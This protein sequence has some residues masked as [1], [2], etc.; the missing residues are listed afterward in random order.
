MHNTLTTKFDTDEWFHWVM[1]WV[2]ADDKI[3]IR[4]PSAMAILYR[5]NVSTP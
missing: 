2:A 3:M 5:Q 1:T 4:M